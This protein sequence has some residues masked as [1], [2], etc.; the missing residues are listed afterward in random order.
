MTEHPDDAAWMV[1]L[2]ERNEQ[3]SGDARAALERHLANCSRCRGRVAEWRMTMT[4]LDEWQVHT[5]RPA[6]RI[7]SDQ[8]PTRW[9]RLLIAASLIVAFV[10]G[11]AV[12]HRNDLSGLKADL[13]AVLKAELKSELEKGWRQPLASEPYTANTA[14][15]KP[16]RPA[17][18]DSAVDARLT[19]FLQHDSQRQVETQQLLNDL[20]RNQVALRQDLESLAVEAESQ[21]LRTRREILRF[22]SHYAANRHWNG[23]NQDLPQHT[24]FI[25]Q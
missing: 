20:L 3:D 23:S 22:E 19:A 18:S 11:Q 9:S 7:S 16:Q 10:L 5:Q 1:Y 17:E 2:Y 6:D 24:L 15:L 12:Q 21:I 4:A 8:R 14:V 13:K 25:N